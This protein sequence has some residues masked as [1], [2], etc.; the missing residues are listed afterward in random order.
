MQATGASRETIRYYVNEGLLPAPH[1]TAKNSAWYGDSHI[2]TIR[3]IRTLQDQH[4]LPLRAIKLLMDDPDS[5]EFSDAQRHVYDMVRRRSAASSRLTSGKTLAEHCE[6]LNIGAEE[7][8]AFSEVGLLSNSQ[9]DQ[10]LSQE[11][12]E[13]LKLWSDVRTAG[14]TAERGFSPVDVG[15]VGDAADILVN[16]MVRSFSDRLDGFSDKE[17]EAL[18]VTIL[19]AVER[20]FGILLERRINDFVGQFNEGRNKDEDNNHD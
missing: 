3:L 18:W 19:P 9:P 2:E 14:L 1:R 20:V 16:Q 5:A 8:A 4:Y 10:L 6:G 12:A 15:L 13:L 17:A 11:D 7:L